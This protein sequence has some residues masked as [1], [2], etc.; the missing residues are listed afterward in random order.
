MPWGVCD[1][2]REKL[3]RQ[4]RR[5]VLSGFLRETLGE[6]ENIAFGKIKFHPLHAMHRKKDDAG[7]EWLAVLDLGSKFVEAGDIDAAQAEAFAGEMEDRAPEFFARVGQ[8]RD[9]KRAGT[10]G[11]TVCGSW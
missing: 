1:R 6:R 5:W 9:H 7:S 10:E 2:V 11:L 8:R 4:N 3:A